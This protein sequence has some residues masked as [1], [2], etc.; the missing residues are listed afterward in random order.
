MFKTSFASTTYM[1]EYV[2]FEGS[3]GRV[4]WQIQSVFVN[5]GLAT[6]RWINSRGEVIIN[7]TVRPKAKATPAI[8]FLQF[9]MLVSMTKFDFY[10]QDGW[11][12]E[13]ASILLSG[14]SMLS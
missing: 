13:T 5:L 12:G 4:R 9:M 1:K 6:F 7:R 10:S 11:M 3:S 8:G 14:C 2:D